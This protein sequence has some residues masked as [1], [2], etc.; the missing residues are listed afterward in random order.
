MLSTAADGAFGATDIASH[1][2]WGLSREL[3]LVRPPLES[4]APSDPTVEAAAG[5]DR[6]RRAANVI[7]AA[8]A[9]IL[10]APVMVLIAIAIK[11]TSRGPVFYKQTRVG[12]DRRRGSGGHWRRKV[13]FGGKLFTIYKFRTMSVPTEKHVDEVW[14]QQNDP[15][16]TSI[17]RVLRKY[18]LD[19]LPQLIN[20]LRGDMNVVGPRPEQP[21]IFLTLREQIARYD[22]RQQV[23]PGI[24]GWAQVNLPYDTCIADVEKKL[25]FDLQ[26]A[27]RAS[28]MTDVTI[29]AK[30]IPVVM[31]RFGGW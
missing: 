8:I 21:R 14:A 15:R 12:I 23:L 3:V 25:E 30:T 6:A 13:D 22:E 19:E 26:Y 28:L 18:R 10:T 5:S 7:V 16:V 29:M 11:L 27:R 2:V 17:G 31:F 1:D 9:L 24:T 4:T 20:V